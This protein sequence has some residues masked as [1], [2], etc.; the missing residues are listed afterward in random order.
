MAIGAI[1]AAQ[2]AGWRVPQ[3]VSVMGFDDIPEATIIRPQLTTIARDLPGI[4]R[5]LGQIL[6]E[7][8]DGEV[9]G[10]SRFFQSQWKLIE[11]ESA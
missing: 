3:D 9:T 1:L 10:E 11:R 6:F 2:E 7:R 4:G 5:Q 8:I